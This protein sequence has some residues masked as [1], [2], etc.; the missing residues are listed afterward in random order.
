[1]QNPRLA[2]RYAKSL[3]DLA[4]E[5]NQVDLICADMKLLQKLGKTNADFIAMLRSP[6]IKPSIKDKI[7]DAVLKSQVSNTTF[8]FIRLLVH[9]NR[10]NVLPEIADAFVD[11]FNQLRGIHRVKLT[12][13]APVSDELKSFIIQKIKS[14]TSF[15][16]IELE[17]LVKEEIVGGF[18]LE[19]GGTFVDA[20]IM[21]DLK[22][23]RRQFLDNQYIHKIR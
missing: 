9:K 10:E 1:M 6:I 12:T 14:S 22:D 18:T 16:N 11:Q 15:Q 3:L 7:I 2:G 13:A 23:I 17:T 20:S 21:R 5:M 19:M 4:A 8:T